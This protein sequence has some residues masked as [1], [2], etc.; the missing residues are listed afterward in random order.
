ME[1][2]LQLEL[3]ISQDDYIEIEI[4]EQELE[5][6]LWKK[7]IVKTFTLES[8][9]SLLA[10]I[11]LLTVSAKGIIATET[12]FLVPFIWIFFLFHF[13]YNYY[14]GVK[15]EFNMAVSH[16]L[17]NK[18]KHT[19]FTPER[20][21]AFFYEDRREFLTNEQ[22]RYFGYDK[23]QNIKIIKHLYIFVMK[24]SK[25]K[26]LRGFAYMVIP[27]RNLTDIK[28]KQLNEICG[29]IVEK[30]DLKEWFKSDIFD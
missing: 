22:R 29:M 13:V 5:A 16:I 8:V 4:L 14:W 19:F 3:D 27:K 10:V 17:K 9:I 11:F 24:R 12:I 7:S 30:Y 23:I 18:D 28:E 21:M 6:K 1:Y 25:E 26:N 2:P 15:K 20:G